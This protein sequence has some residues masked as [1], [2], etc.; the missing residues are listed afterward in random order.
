M[1]QKKTRGI[2]NNK[3]K[4]VIKNIYVNYYNT[5][6]LDSDEKTISKNVADVFAVMSN[7]TKEKENE[8]YNICLFVDYKLKKYK[9]YIGD[10]KLMYDFTEL[11]K[12]SLGDS[13]DTGIREKYEKQI[14]N[15]LQDDK[16]L[17]QILAK[18]Q[19]DHKDLTADVFLQR[20]SK[21]GVN[22]LCRKKY[23]NNVFVNITNSVSNKFKQ[24]W[25]SCCS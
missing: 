3:Q 23:G 8:T 14:H 21:Y 7:Y 16:I 11:F 2:I 9:I 4:D 25:F 13:D 18:M 10:K 5:L 22:I 17:G 1:E 19:Q 12:I 24:C 15:V 20:C 6:N